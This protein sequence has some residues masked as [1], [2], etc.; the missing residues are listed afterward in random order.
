ME[1]DTITRSPWR[2][3]ELTTRSSAAKLYCGS[4]G[5]AALKPAGRVRAFGA[6]AIWFQNADTRRRSTPRFTNVCIS[7][8][9]CS[10]EVAFSSSWSSMIDTSAR[11][12]A[13]AAPGRASSAVSERDGGQ[14]A[15]GD[16]GAG[17]RTFAASN[18]A[19]RGKSRRKAGA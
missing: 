1:I 5:S 8:S 17:L 10:W 11:L 9:T 15:A 14:R 12:S 6:G 16:V 4:A 3:A 13:R 7:R 19:G 18:R 2:D